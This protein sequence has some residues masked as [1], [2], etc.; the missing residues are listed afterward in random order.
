MRDETHLL[1]A[2]EAGD[3]TARLALADLLEERGDPR[4]SWVREPRVFAWMLPGLRDPVPALVETAAG[5]DWEKARD[6]RDLLPLL[7]AAAV[8]AL[9]AEAESG[10]EWAG[11]AIGGMRAEDVAEFLPHLLRLAAEEDLD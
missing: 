6:A 8:P 1:A 5:D 7:G 4:A 11:E 10:A 3:D 2:I 9:L